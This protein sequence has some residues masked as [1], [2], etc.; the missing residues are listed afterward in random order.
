MNI[1]KHTSSE[2]PIVL[3]DTGYINFYSLHATEYWFKLACDGVP[4]PESDWM[5]CIQF[6]EKYEQMYLTRIEKLFAKPT[7]QQLIPISKLKRTKNK[8]YEE[9]LD[10]LEKEKALNKRKSRKRQNKTSNR[11]TNKEITAEIR[12]V[13]KEIKKN[14]VIM[15]PK[16]QMIFAYDCPRRYIWRQEYF[17]TYKQNRDEKYKSSDWKGGGIMGHTN[18]T[19]IPQYVK[20]HDVTIL[21]EKKME[22]DDV[23]ALT[24]RYIRHN[25]PNKHI[26]IITNDHDMLQLLDSKTS[27]MNLKGLN[28]SEK[29]VGS[30]RGDLLMK[31]LCGDPSD[32]IKSC[33]PKCGKVTAMRLIRDEHKL[34]EKLN[35]NIKW[36]EAYEFN[37]KMIDFDEIP[38]DLVDTFYDNHDDYF[39]PVIECENDSWNNSD[40][41]NSSENS[42]EIIDLKCN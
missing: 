19:L 34:E 4:E 26:I 40:G 42:Y 7:F 25:Y 11:R 28:L 39:N 38:D 16:S 35:S 1:Y 3:L 31:V 15:V 9:R 5:D 36:R 41:N 37:C 30:S 29:S 8:K 13:K 24:H 12:Q 20:E 17:P 18:R 22:G 32:N 33:F 6:R 14:N 10:E 2:Y 21:G 23:I 27:M